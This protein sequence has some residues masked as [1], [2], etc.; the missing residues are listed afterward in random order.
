MIV[1]QARKEFIMNLWKPKSLVSMQSSTVAV[2]D[3]RAF[4]LGLDELYRNAMKSFETQT[5]LPCARAVAK[6]LRVQPA[7]VPIEG[8]YYESPKLKEYFRL[9]RGLQEVSE[10]RETQV[11]DLS[12]FQLMWELTSSPLYGRPQ[13]KGK[14]LPVGRD[15]LSQA[16]RDT[17]PDWSL[18]RLVKVAYEVALGRDDYSLV[19]LAA[20]TQDAVVLTAVRESVVLY[21]EVAVLGIHV[22]PEFEYEWRVDGALAAAANRFIEAFNHFVPGALPMAEAANAEEYFKAYADNE[23]IGRCVRIG[24]TPD[25][26][27]HYHW[28]IVSERF[29]PEGFELSVDE[30]WDKEL[31][32]TEQ[33]REVQRHPAHMKFF[34]TDGVPDRLWGWT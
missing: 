24:R 1:L 25:D 12:E 3:D 30:F 20:R 31:W 28:A 13:R 8:Y 26:T 29:P 11:R 34:H 18:E 32:T 9:M 14:L 4:M 6:K 2:V 7:N 15:P 10:E 17:M 22:E 23:I 27:R 16:L 21:A 19:G 5:L 33:Y